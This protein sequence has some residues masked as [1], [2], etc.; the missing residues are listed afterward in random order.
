MNNRNGHIR[1]EVLEEF[2]GDSRHLK[3]P[4][5]PSIPYLKVHGQDNNEASINLFL[6]FL[7][8][9]SIKHFIWTI[10]VNLRL[11]L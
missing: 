10:D 9:Q 2:T 11:V 1:E 5:C 4:S 8:Y 7:F 6:G 3:M